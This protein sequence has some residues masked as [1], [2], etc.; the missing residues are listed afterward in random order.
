MTAKGREK[1]ELWLK[2]FGEHIKQTRL[3]KGLSGTD[4]TNLLFIEKT[5]LSRLEKGKVNP[6]VY[7]IKQICEV[8]EIKMSGFFR[9]FKN[10]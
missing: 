9:N 10:E 7:L 8:L 6:S 5:N 3:K 4:L 1:K 2:A